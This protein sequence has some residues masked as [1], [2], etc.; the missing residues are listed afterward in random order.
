MPLFI[1]LPPIC[2]AHPPFA[3][4]SKKRKGGQQ[5]PL[6]LCPTNLVQSKCSSPVP[7]NAPI[8]SQRLCECEVCFR[9]FAMDD[10]VS[11]LFHGLTLCLHGH[12]VHSVHTVINNHHEPS[13][14]HIYP[15]A[16]LVHQLYPMQLFITK[17]HV[18]V[19]IRLFL[20]YHKESSMDSDLPDASA[21]FHLPWLHPPHLP[22][23]D[24]CL[25]PTMQIYPTP[26]PRLHPTEQ[27]PNLCTAGRTNDPVEIVAPPA[28]LQ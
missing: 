16:S 14:P 11:V 2:L 21:R 1:D 23:S 13:V 4:L 19:A 12:H 25:A 6:A 8:Y 27:E 17:Y 24:P 15:D 20:F 7:P 28:H 26:N 18:R 3:W 10:P 22:C 9:C 5:V